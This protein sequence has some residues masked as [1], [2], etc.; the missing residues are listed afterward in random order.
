MSHDCLVDSA[1]VAL[2]ALS[3]SSGNR[4][5]RQ[6]TGP[7]LTDDQIIHQDT[8]LGSKGARTTQPSY[9]LP[10][11]PVAFRTPTPPPGLPHLA[12][13]VRLSLCSS[14]CLPAQPA[15]CPPGWRPWRRLR[16]VC[17]VPSSHLVENAGCGKSIQFAKSRHRCVGQLHQL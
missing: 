8:L 14:L 16:S 13:V 5:V 10:L 17:Q 15:R 12:A 9:D 7:G 3:R 2:I 6:Q 11:P 1:I 4:H